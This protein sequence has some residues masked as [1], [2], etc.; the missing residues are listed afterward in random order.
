MRKARILVLCTANSCRSQIAE[1]L[2]RK[3]FADLA[4]VFSAGAK[5]AE[6]VH[7]RAIQVLLERDIDIS[8]HRPQNTSEFLNE[9]FDFI[10]TT[11]DGALEACPIFP[12]GGQK[13]HWGLPDP[14]GATG[15]EDE[16]MAAFRATADALEARLDELA[17]MIE[18]VAKR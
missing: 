5:P 1:G 6:K 13:I 12:G 7:P 14:A 10:I 18:E 15:S 11:C 17:P 2:I 9:S 16:I 3:K 8:S 4:E